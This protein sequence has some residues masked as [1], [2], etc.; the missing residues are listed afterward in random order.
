MSEASTFLTRMLDVLC[1]G[2]GRIAFAHDSRSMTY[3]ETFERLRRLHGMLQA[4]GIAP[5][6]LVAII[7]GNAPERILL[8]IA[9]Q[10]RGARVVHAG[11]PD[12]LGGLRPDHIISADPEGP[13]LSAR[14]DPLT[15]A[16]DEVDIALPRSVEALFT[17]DGEVVSLGETYEQLARESRPDPGR[18]ER[19]LLIA[20]MSHPIGNRIACKTLLAGD[21]VVIHERTAEEAMPVPQGATRT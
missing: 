2:G 21:T 3:R 13:L 8:Q 10:L 18:A 5:G 7:G 19:V 11:S 1:D 4:E 14:T 17:T 15:G 6:Q 12:A 20:P 16:V 9:A